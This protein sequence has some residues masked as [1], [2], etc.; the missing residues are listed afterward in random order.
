M[1]WFEGAAPIG[2]KW[3]F[4]TKRLADG[5]FEKTKARLV[6]RGDSQRPG[7][8][9]GEIFA[10]VAHNTLARLLFSVSAAC[11]LEVDLVDI[12]QAFLNADLQEEIYMKPA[13]GVNEILGIPE[14]Y[15]LR[16]KRNL[17][18][19]KQAPR[20]W[21]LTFLKWMEGQEGF[22]KAST[23]DCL[24]KKEYEKNGKKV[25]ILLLMYVDDNVII[26]N[27]REELD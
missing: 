18:C 13:P 8:D 4:R 27:D 24:L 22:V 15:L 25:F 19:L 21:A 3:V 1:P 14:G 9:Y 6:I 17:Y 10:P 16:L 23:D 11:D 20:N 2:S 12:C 5:T 7:I 26:S